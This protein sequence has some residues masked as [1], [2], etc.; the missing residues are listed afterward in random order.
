MKASDIGLT[1]TVA[2][3]AIEAIGR[4]LV[5]NAERIA[6]ESDYMVEFELNAK[7]HTKTDEPGAGCPEISIRNQ[8]YIPITDE[9]QEAIFKAC[10]DTTE[11]NGSYNDRKNALEMANDTSDSITF[12][13]DGTTKHCLSCRSCDCCLG[14]CSLNCNNVDIHD[15]ACEYYEPF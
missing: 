11:T 9:L 13:Y 6:G 14:Y 3:K 7:F 2:K 1:K 5:D 8:H 12:T 15:P 10:A 4:Y